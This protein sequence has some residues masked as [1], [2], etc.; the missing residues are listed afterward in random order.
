MPRVGSAEA[1]AGVALD[2]L[3]G[4]ADTGEALEGVKTMRPLGV[5]PDVDFVLVHDG[6]LD[7]VDGQR[8]VEDQA[9]G[10][11]GEDVNLDEGLAAGIV[12][13]E[14]VLPA[15]FEGEGS[16][17]RGVFPWWPYLQCHESEADRGR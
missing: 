11:G 6:E 9:E 7:T 16:A 13:A 3:A 10:H 17:A 5:V 8:L 1:V 15:P 12:G 2:G 14:G 4:E